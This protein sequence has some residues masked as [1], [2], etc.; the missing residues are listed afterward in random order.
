LFALTIK[1]IKTLVEKV[2]E[3]AKNNSLEDFNYGSPS[4]YW[5]SA[6]AAGLISQKEHDYI[7]DWMGDRFYYTG[8]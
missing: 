7:R 2:N 5:A 4:R 1:E 3:W 6:K 8:D